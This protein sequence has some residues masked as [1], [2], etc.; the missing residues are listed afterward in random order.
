[1]QVS[2]LSS[3]V[4][5]VT[6]ENTN[7]QKGPPN[8]DP[9]T[10]QHTDTFQESE[11]D[12]TLCSNIVKQNIL[13]TMKSKYMNISELLINIKKLNKWCSPSDSSS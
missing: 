6:N 4:T 13:C 9:H 1:M 7:M 11:T 5:M 2:L 3:Y 10:M 12:Y 8:C